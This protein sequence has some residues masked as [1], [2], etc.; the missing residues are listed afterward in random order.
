MSR[1][2]R[3]KTNDDGIS[4]K[5]MLCEPTELLIQLIIK[6]YSVQSQQV[7]QGMNAFPRRINLNLESNNC[8]SSFP[9]HNKNK[10][11]RKK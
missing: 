9:I 11:S 4:F 7:N 3:K 10:T 8:I 5:R 6:L 2:L 1:N